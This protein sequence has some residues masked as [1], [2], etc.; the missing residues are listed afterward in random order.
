MSNYATQTPDKIQ[1]EDDDGSYFPKQIPLPIAQ[2]IQFAEPHVLISEQNE[3]V[4]PWYNF[5]ELIQELE[6]QA[7]VSYYQGLYFASF[8]CSVS[9]LEYILKYEYV[10]KTRDEGILQDNTT[11]FGKMVNEKLG[12]INLSK[13]K[14]ELTNVNSLRNG[15]FHLNTDKLKSSVVNLRTK[16]TQGVKINIMDIDKDSVETLP[17]DKQYHEDTFVIPDNREMSKISYH[18]YCLLNKIADERYGSNQQIG[19]I[20]ESI[21]DYESKYMK[22]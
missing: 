7:F 6:R 15:F 2:F 10:I 17:M 21:K 12:S 11:T 1:V 14:E 22:K 3:D 4:K 20:K 5:R 16:E 9:C 19:F 8:M 13:Y 18:T